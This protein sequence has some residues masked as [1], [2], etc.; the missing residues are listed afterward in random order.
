MIRV[1]AQAGTR[2]DSVGFFDELLLDQWEVPFGSWV[3]QMVDWIDLHMDWLLDAIRWPFAFLLENFVEGFMAQVPWVFMVVLT[4]LIGSLVRTT[5]VGI[6]AGFALA[7]CGLLG[8]E[9]WVET[10]RTIGMV[11]VAVVLCAI[12]GIPLGIACGRFQRT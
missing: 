9:Y 1:L 2:D 12:V 10:I 11:L 6:S 4:I 5:K 3:D 8:P 7:L